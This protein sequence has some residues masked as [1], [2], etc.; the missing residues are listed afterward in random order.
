MTRSLG[1]DE[2]RQLR[3]IGHCGDRVMRGEGEHRE[4]NAPL[5]LAAAVP[6]WRQ[7]G[8]R[9]LAD[10]TAVARHPRPM[11]RPD[12]GLARMSLGRQRRPGLAGGSCP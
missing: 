5:C 3:R 4:R 6:G 8:A 11:R 7:P 1:E 9:W 10:P 12:D 2:P